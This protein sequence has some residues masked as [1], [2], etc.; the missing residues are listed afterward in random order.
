[1][2]IF[3]KTKTSKRKEPILKKKISNDEGKKNYLKKQPINKN[4]Q[5]KLRTTKKIKDVQEQ[6][7]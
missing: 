1:M 3:I 5:A 7:R 2:L 6:A 4:E